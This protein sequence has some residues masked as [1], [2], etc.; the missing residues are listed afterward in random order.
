MYQMIKRL[1]FF[2]VG[3]PAFGQTVEVEWDPKGDT[4]T[5]RSGLVA[6][7]A[8]EAVEFDLPA[9]AVDMLVDMLVDA[10]A[11][12]PGRSADTPAEAL[13]RAKADY[14]KAVEARNKGLPAE[15]LSRAQADY[16]KSIRLSRAV[17]SCHHGTPASVECGDCEPEGYTAREEAERRAF[18]DWH[19]S[20][21]DEGGAK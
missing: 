13:A 1:E 20:S 3:Q 2:P 16:D 19:D 12:R 17:E 14:D 21:G 7:P 11:D 9:V 4:L 10:L 8:D 6:A 15:A 5:V 18:S